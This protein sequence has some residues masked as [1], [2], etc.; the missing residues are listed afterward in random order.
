MLLGGVS[1]DPRSCSLCLTQRWSGQALPQLG[2]TPP[3]PL[4]HLVPGRMSRGFFLPSPGLLT[5]CF[6]VT[7]VT[8]LVVVFLLKQRGASRDLLCEQGLS[9]KPV[10]SPGGRKLLL[11]AT[12]SRRQM[13]L[14]SESVSSI[15]ETVTRPHLKHKN[16]AECEKMLE[17]NFLIAFRAQKQ[18]QWVGGDTAFLQKPQIPLWRQVASC[19]LRD[20]AVSGMGALACP[21]HPHPW[22]SVSTPQHSACSRE[23]HKVTIRLSLKKE[24]HEPRSVPTMGCWLRMGVHLPQPALWPPVEYL[25]LEA[26]LFNE[27][28][29]DCSDRCYEDRILGLSSTSSPSCTLVL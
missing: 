7:G 1:H 18:I 17:K 20:T 15:M 26:I 22:D 13:K 8:Q 14:P 24:P 23:V 27:N 21:V 4:G 9:R 5:G 25:C 6:E 28:N 2:W 10:V 19:G 12:Q 16:L 11:W 29:M 3:C